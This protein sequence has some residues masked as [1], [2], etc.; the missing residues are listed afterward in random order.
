MDED[1]QA[2]SS[3]GSAEPE[4]ANGV[5]LI[6]Q[7]AQDLLLRIERHRA[8]LHLTAGPDRRNAAG[9]ACDSAA[10]TGPAVA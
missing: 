9:Q 6:A 7:C 2:N 3:M 8:T 4:V 1:V 10:D 5:D